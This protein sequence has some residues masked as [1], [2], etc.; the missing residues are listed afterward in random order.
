MDVINQCVFERLG[1]QERPQISLCIRTKGADC[2]YGQGFT[3]GSGSRMKLFGVLQFSLWS[4][5]YGLK[6]VERS[7]KM[8]YEDGLFNFT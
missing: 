8:F 2:F 4:G 5:F 6:G 7:L 3:K 1:T